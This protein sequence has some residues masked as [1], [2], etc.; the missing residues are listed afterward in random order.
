MDIKIETDVPY[1]SCSRNL[2]RNTM[3]LRSLHLFVMLACLNNIRLSCTHLYHP[4]S[5]PSHNTNLDVSLWLHSDPMLRVPHLFRC[6][7]VDLHSP[8]MTEAICQLE[9]GKYQFA[10]S[11]A[12][13]LHSGFER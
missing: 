11:S 12:T 4:D 8:A 7:F 3:L 5:R 10:L 2:H 13:F 1:L 6:K 9:D